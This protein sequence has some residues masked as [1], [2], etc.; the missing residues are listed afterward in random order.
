MQKLL[1]FVKDLTL[2]LNEKQQQF[3][4]FSLVG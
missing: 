2:I 4:G 3:S 1:S